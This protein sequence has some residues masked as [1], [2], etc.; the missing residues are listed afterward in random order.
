MV[1]IIEY[2]L[3]F[4]AEDKLY[5]LNGSIFVLGI[6]GDGHTINDRQTFED[7]VYRFKTLIV[8]LTTT[9]W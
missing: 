6:I 5:E 1:T 2:A 8:R 4:G 7:R 3:A 9:F